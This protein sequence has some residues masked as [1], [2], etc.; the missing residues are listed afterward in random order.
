[1]RKGFP[2][3]AAFGPICVL[4][5]AL[6]LTPA[7]RRPTIQSTLQ[8]PPTPAQLAE[9][10]V[11]PERTRDLYLGRRRSGARARSRGD[12]HRHRDQA[13]RLQP[14]LHRQGPTRPRVEREVSA[15]GAD[16]SRRVA[17]PLGHRLPSA[18][19]LLPVANG[20]ADKATSPNPQLPARFR[21]TDAGVPR[22]RRRRHLVVL[23]QPV[24]RHPPVEWA[25]RPPGHARQLRS[26]GRAERDLH[27]RPNRSKGRGAGTSRA[28][29]GRRSAAPACSI[30]PRGD[31]EVFEQTPFI[32]G[33]VKAERA[34][35]LSR[36][37]QGAVRADITR[38]T[39]AGSV[40]ASARSPTISWQDAFR[41]GGYP[42]SHC[43]SL[44]PP[45]RSRKSPKALQLK[46]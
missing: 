11:E 35:R 42:T 32:T 39:C 20:Q 14:R 36:P 26:Q 15:R 27:A 12:L 13:R 5:V 41:A 6:L 3:P 44:H 19:G 40:S 45:A 4:G 24:R 30:A 28:I 8:G 25:A 34:V 2:G 10:W 38:P 23:H 9:L 46:D 1:M 37:P 43:R 22:A 31:P 17:D 18:A 29:S 16:R 21:E 7:C 33:V